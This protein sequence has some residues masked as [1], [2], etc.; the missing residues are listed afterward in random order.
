MINK[1]LSIGSNQTMATI[2]TIDQFPNNYYV[3]SK[4]IKVKIP[5]VANSVTFTFSIIDEDGD[6]RYSKGSIAPN[7]VII[8]SSREEERYITNGYKISILPSG[9]TGT[10]IDVIV[11]INAVHMLEG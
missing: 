6:V 4:E 7:S 3:L 11:K 5:A 1:T 9:A 10:D 2:A 8:I